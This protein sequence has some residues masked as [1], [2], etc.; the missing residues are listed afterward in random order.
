M[1]RPLTRFTKDQMLA[2]KAGMSVKEFRRWTQKANDET[3]PLIIETAKKKI[4]Q[5][6]AKNPTKLSISVNRMLKKYGWR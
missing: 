2:I 5:G 3:C 6:L 4:E 1:T